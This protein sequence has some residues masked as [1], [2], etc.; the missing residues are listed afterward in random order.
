M[1]ALQSAA[2]TF[3]RFLRERAR[4]RTSSLLVQWG[5]RVAIWPRNRQKYDGQKNT[6]IEATQGDGDLVE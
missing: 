4:V 5:W 3:S 1:P 2:S 6:E